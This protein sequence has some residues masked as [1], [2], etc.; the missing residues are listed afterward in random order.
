MYLF[1]YNVKYSTCV[2]LSS[3]VVG[4]TFGITFILYIFS[5]DRITVIDNKDLAANDFP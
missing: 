1:I 3:V 5:C 2:F 4:H